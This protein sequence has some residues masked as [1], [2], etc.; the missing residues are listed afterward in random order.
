VSTKSDH[1]WGKLF[2]RPQGV[3]WQR[4]RIDRRINDDYYLIE[5]YSW[6]DR[7]LTNMTVA[8]I[9]SMTD[10]KLYD[11]ND[12]VD[13]WEQATDKIMQESRRSKETA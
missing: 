3:S 6:L 11:Q 10:W 12:G 5:L 2:I 1:L 9:A 4:G 7:S 8:S 13:A